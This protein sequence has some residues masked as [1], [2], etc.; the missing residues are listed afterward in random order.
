MMTGASLV[1]SMIYAV[2]FIAFIAVGLWW[3][4]K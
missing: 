4:N 3:L 2:V 1:A